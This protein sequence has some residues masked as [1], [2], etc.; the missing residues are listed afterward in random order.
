MT[1]PETARNNSP[2]DIALSF[3][4]V[5]SLIFL[6]LLLFVSQ[7]DGTMVM[8]TGSA[9]LFCAALSVSTLSGKY[10]SKRV[11]VLLAVAIALL[12]VVPGYFLVATL[13]A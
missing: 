4:G 1:S 10:M 12:A 11:R 6:G 7:S 13:L 3:F 2:R 9:A 8:F 5:M